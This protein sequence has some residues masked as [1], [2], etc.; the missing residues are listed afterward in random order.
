MSVDA[1]TQE[2]LSDEVYDEMNPVIARCMDDLDVGG[3]LPAVAYQNDM[4]DLRAMPQ[5]STMKQ[6][7]AEIR[8]LNRQLGIDDRAR[9]ARRD[10]KASV[11]HLAMGDRERKA[12]GAGCTA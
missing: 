4:G 2:E 10:G 5:L 12:A 1:L 6:A 9:P 3:E 11:V 7:N 8:A